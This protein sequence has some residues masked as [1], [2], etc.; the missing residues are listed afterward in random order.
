MG[1]GRIPILLFF[2]INTLIYFDACLKSFRSDLVKGTVKT[3]QILLKILL[4][5]T[6]YN[7]ALCLVFMSL[8]TKMCV[9][10]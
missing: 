9:Q 3:L 4:F 5:T 8:Y 2:K 7:F 1:V 6:Q 10:D